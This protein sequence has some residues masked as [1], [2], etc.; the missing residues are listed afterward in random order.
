MTNFER[1]KSSVER[2]TETE[3]TSESCENINEKKSVDYYTKANEEANLFKKS[4]T[5]ETAEVITCQS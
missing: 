3:K 1:L 4:A 2:K 5:N